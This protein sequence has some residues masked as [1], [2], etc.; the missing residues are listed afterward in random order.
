MAKTKTPFLSLGSQG[1][2]GGSIT[3][4]R[5]GSLT[6]VRTKPIP[7][8]AK[9]PTQ[10]NRRQLYKECVLY[11]SALT[12]QEKEKWRGLK[13]HLS[14]FPTFMSPCLSR[15]PPLYHEITIQVAAGP[16]DCWTLNSLWDIAASQFQAGYASAI[17]KAG[18]SAARFLNITIPAGSTIISANLLL[19]CQTS[20]SKDYV[21][22]RLR[23]EKNINPATFSTLANFNLRA[24]TIAYMNWDNIPAWTKDTQYTSPAYDGTRYFKDIIQEVINLPGWANGNPI[25]ILWDDFEKRS[26]QVTA[27]RRTAYSWNGSATKAPE[28]YIKYI[29]PPSLTRP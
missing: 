19:T 10:L 24:W 13:P 21:R 23:A 28:L 9:S 12:P 15:L 20:E 1:S 2:I 14:P 16:D 6:R 8:N 17:Y 18:G 22:T 7:T 4:Q 11:W 25:A 5:S 26:S 29:L 27:T 3:T